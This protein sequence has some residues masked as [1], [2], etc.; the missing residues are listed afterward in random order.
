MAAPGGEVEVGGGAVVAD[1][2]PASL[3]R[4]VANLVK[5]ALRHGVEVRVHVVASDTTIVIAC[6]DDGPGI[7]EAQR[8]MAMR[9]FARLDAARSNTAGNVGLGLSIV[10]DVA[11][12][13]GGTL[14]LGASS[15]GGLK[16]EIV[17]PRTV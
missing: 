3:E 8:H 4:A 6:E 11:R 10:R 9:P 7:P 2:Y 14:R 5:N 12:A 1:V 16:A 17:L 15:M 13:H